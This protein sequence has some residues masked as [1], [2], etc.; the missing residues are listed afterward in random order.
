MLPPPKTV[1]SHPCVFELK[2][3]DST[4][5]SITSEAKLPAGQSI[6]ISITDK[7]RAILAAN[8]ST[9]QAARPAGQDAPQTQ[10]VGQ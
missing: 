4:A 10:T 3:G 7:D 5:I 8:L 6:F 1:W 2:P 9:P